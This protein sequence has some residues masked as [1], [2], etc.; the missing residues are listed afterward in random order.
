MH[1]GDNTTIHRYDLTAYKLGICSQRSCSSN[2]RPHLSF[3]RA[4]QAIA[5]H[6]SPSSACHETMA[7]HN[8]LLLLQ[9]V[10]AFALAHPD[11]PGALCTAFWAVNKS[12]F[13]PI[14]TTLLVKRAQVINLCLCAILLDYALGDF[15]ISP[16]NCWTHV[17]TRRG[18]LYEAQL[19][20]QLFH[21]ASTWKKVMVL[22]VALVVLM[23]A[24]RAFSRWRVVKRQVQLPT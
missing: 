19:S 23:S 21:D 17:L 2:T 16:F 22:V 24:N 20:A 9:C 7:S 8:F 6:T 10:C 13:A 18:A 3:L 1:K 5:L 11:L 15:E 14:Y 4:S 12:C